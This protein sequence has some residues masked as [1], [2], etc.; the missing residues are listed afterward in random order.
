MCSSDLS[1]RAL[2]SGTD[3]NLFQNSD[4]GCPCVSAIRS[5]GKS[6]YRCPTPRNQP[7]LSQPSG[8]PSL[9]AS[10]PLAMNTQ[11]VIDCCILPCHIGAFYLLII[12]ELCVTRY[13]GFVISCHLC[14]FFFSFTQPV[15]VTG[16]RHLRHRPVDSAI[17]FY[18]IYS[19]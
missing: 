3:S 18:F 17:L 9:K 6:G 4:V 14:Y 11:A 16:R 1:R 12:C 7:D 8:S 13:R 10:Y 2:T 19:T 15:A 5:P